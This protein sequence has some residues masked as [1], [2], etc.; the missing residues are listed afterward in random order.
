[1]HNQL[2]WGEIALRLA[3]AVAGGLV[4]GADRGEHGRPAG[5]RTTLLVCLAAAI[6]MIQMNLLL[7]LSGKTSDS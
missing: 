4:I 1:L 7:P 6:S 3:L 5:L 2:T